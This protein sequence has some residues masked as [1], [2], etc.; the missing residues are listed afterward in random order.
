M[1]YGS[2][3]EEDPKSFLDEVYKVLDIMGLLR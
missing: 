1:F 3:V 2:E